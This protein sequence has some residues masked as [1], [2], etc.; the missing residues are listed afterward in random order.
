MSDRFSHVSDD[1]LREAFLEGC[2]AAEFLANQFASAA[3]VFRLLADSDRP[4]QRRVLTAT[5]EHTIDPF[6]QTAGD[7][8]EEMDSQLDDEQQGKLT[9]AYAKVGYVMKHFR[10]DEWPNGDATDDAG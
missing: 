6:M 8:L 10:C 7:M 9:S 1:Q 4:I 2:D 3:K 5:L